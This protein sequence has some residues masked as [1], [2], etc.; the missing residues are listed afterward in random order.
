MAGRITLIQ[1]VLS[2]ITTYCLSFYML[3]KK[4]IREI[5]K[6]QHKFLWSGNNTNGKSIPWVSWVDVC[7][8]K[9]EGGLGIKDLRVFNKALFGK[10][11]ARFLSNP[12]SLWAKVL[13]LKYKKLETGSLRE[14]ECRVSGWWRDLC[15][16][17][18]FGQGLTEEFE[19]I[20]GNGVDTSFWEENWIGGTP[21]R[22]KF[23]SL[24][25]LSTQKTAKV[26]GCGLWIDDC[27][28]WELN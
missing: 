12:C 3:P 6:M 17:G 7:R 26:S 27:W 1:A 14:R 2:A 20:I 24:Y 22:L 28:A 4:I 21:M 5:T 16:Y 9:Q 23:P 11:S 25:Q 13:H 8:K 19:K 15:E 18:E 10:W